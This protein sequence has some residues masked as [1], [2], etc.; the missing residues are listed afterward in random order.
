MEKFGY[1]IYDNVTRSF[2]TFALSKTEVVIYGNCEEA[3]EDCDESQIVLKL[4]KVG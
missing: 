1:V 4:T 3:L 2:V